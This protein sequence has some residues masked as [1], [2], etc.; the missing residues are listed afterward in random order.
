MSCLVKNDREGFLMLGL[1]VEDS[2]HGSS[3]LLCML[4]LLLLP[5]IVV[6][7]NEEC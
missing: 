4:L 2:L 7:S 6:I 1:V 3:I 5:V